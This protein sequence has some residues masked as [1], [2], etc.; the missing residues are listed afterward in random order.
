V[1]GEATDPKAKPGAAGWAATIIGLL[2][3]KYAGLNLLIPLAGA[4]ATYYA[5]KK[6][7]PTEKEIWFGAVS[8][9]T[10]HALWFLLGLAVLGQ[11]NA[12]LLDPILLLLGALWLFLRPGT[13]PVLVVSAFQLAGLAY[14]LYV[15]GGTDFGTA[16]NKALFV[17]VLFR[18]LAIGLM[19]TGLYKFRKRNGAAA[20]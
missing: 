16:E 2:A 11:I 13:T 6:I 7:A 5:L 15:F 12:N 8:V 1:S 3:G 20:P 14:N 19:A 17:H 9:Q 18:A 10:G 4:G